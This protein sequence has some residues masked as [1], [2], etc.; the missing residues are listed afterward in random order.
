MR[1]KNRERSASAVAV[2]LACSLAAG[3]TTGGPAKTSAAGRKAT[4][5][6]TARVVTL[7]NAQDY[8]TLAA[9]FPAPSEFQ[10]P[11]SEQYRR[12]I[13]RLMRTYGLEFGSVSL[14]DRALD[15]TRF[16]SVSVNSPARVDC[17]ITERSFHVE[18]SEL[19]KGM[20][21][22]MF[23]DDRPEPTLVSLAFGLPASRPDAW[24]KVVGVCIVTMMAMRWQNNT[25]A[26]AAACRKRIPQ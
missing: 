5:D 12:E 25:S 24:E 15:G 16:Y 2:F 9:M 11:E 10:K 23:C 20:L 3:C 1:K 21:R 22:V 13:R 7:I 6:H 26:A 14:G 17:H 4:Y 19:Q 8:A 18:Y